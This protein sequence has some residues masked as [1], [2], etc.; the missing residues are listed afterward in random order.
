MEEGAT[1]H[2]LTE[3]SCVHCISPGLGKKRGRT[4]ERKKGGGGGKKFDGSILVLLFGKRRNN[5]NT[6][7]LEHEYSP[8]PPKTAFFSVRREKRFTRKIR[9]ILWR[10]VH[11]IVR[12][13]HPREK[14][15][16]EGRVKKPEGL[17]PEI[18]F[19]SND[20]FASL[21]S[22][23]FSIQRCFHF[24]SRENPYPR[25]VKQSVSYN[26]PISRFR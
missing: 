1:G 8:P 19:S 4:R 22:A 21:K 2:K 20:R 16:G 9:G 5:E 3:H 14:T 26:P 17:S 18:S 11:W 24:S 15:R 23:R 10:I 7:Y 12:P 6:W 25:R 13:C